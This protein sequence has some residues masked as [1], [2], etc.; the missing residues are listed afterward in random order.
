MKKMFEQHAVARHT[1]L[2]AVIDATY[3]LPAPY[4]T[5]V[6]APASACAVP[7]SP[8]AMPEG[9]GTASPDTMAHDGVALVA[10]DDVVVVR[11]SDVE[12]SAVTY[13]SK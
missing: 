10:N 3:M 1:F 7:L 13:A 8:H 2:H 12:G 6:P 11:V 5:I 9:C 4:P